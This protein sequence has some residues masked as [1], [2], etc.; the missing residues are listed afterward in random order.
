MGEHEQGE[1]EL[2]RDIAKRHVDKVD[3][4]RR[5]RGREVV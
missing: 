2:R 1:G 4:S 3:N 5:R